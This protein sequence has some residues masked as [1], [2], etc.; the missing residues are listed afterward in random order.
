M[1][2][3]WLRRRRRRRLLAR[4]L[5]PEDLAALEALPYGARLTDVERARWRDL[6]REIEDRIHWEGRGG[7]E[8]TPTMRWTIAG[9][10]AR[11]VI[12]LPDGA[13]DRVRTVLLTPRKFQP[14]EPAVD[15]LGIVHQDA[16]HT[17]EA[18]HEGVV[19]LSWSDVRRALDRPGEGYDVVVHEFAHQLD[20]GRDGWFDGTPDLGSVDDRVRWHEVMQ[21]EFE[22][23]RRAAMAKRR[24]FLDPYGATDPSEF[25]ACVSEEFFDSPSDLREHH[26]EL[27]A[28]L[29]SF[30]RQ[31]P[32][33]RDDALTDDDDPEYPP[34]Q[35]ERS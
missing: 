32:A 5:P 26:P 6:A 33:S 16:R 13:F 35:P 15:E 34:K 4:P 9:G 25:F 3:S 21:R 23:L 11:L 8:V 7:I 2:F 31:D 24:T 1:L 10:A 18:W 12:G 19:V 29:K 14:S 20:L 30:Y 22:G 17:G 28:V 27:Y